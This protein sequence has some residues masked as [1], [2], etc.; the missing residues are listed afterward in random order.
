[1]YM[2]RRKANARNRS[3][4]AKLNMAGLPG[5]VGRGTLSKCIR[6][7]GNVTLK[8]RIKP[9]IPVDFYTMPT[10]N[11]VKTQ[12][13]LSIEQLN[14]INYFENYPIIKQKNYYSEN[15]IPYS[16]VY[17]R[18]ID[19]D[20]G[21]V[22]LTVPAIY[23][24]QETIT[25][26]P[27]PNDDFFPRMNQ[28]YPMGNA[29]AYHLGFF[30]ALTIE[31]DNILLDLNGKTLK[32][33][34]LHNIQQRFYANI[35]LASAPF[36]PTQGPAD[37]GSTIAIPKN[38]MIKNGTLGLSS[39]HGI[40]GNK[41][42]KVIIQG[43]TINN[44][45][46]AAIAL[47]GTNNSI[48]DNINIEGTSLDIKVLS[49]YSSGRFI[50]RFL[51]NVKTN[52]PGAF[53][54]VF[55]T[56]ISI[57]SIISELNIKLEELRLSVEN[58][59]TLPVSIFTNTSG[60]YDGNVYGI[61]L[62]KKG[63]VVNGFVTSLDDV[64]TGNRD[65]LLN[66]I[67]I[68]NIISTP[69]EIVG[70]SCPHPE[71]G[72]YGA[73]VQVGPAGDV[74]QI[75]IISDV[76]GK[77]IPNVLSNV[78]IIIGKYNDPK[79]GTTCIS[80]EVISWVEDQTVDISNIIHLAGRYFTDGGDSMAHSMKGNIGMFI[81]SGER[82][83]LNNV[84]INTVK[85]NGSLV[86]TDKFLETVN[87]KGAVSFGMVIAGSNMVDL[88]DVTVNNVFSHNG[89]SNGI[90]LKASTNITQNNIS[91]NNVT[92]NDSNSSTKLILEN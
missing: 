33:S 71:T 26:H 46:V 32:Q 56:I 90:M 19:F 66:N 89:D 4:G 42:E 83:R 39:H 91:I 24:L 21:T 43:L 5:L 54:E 63:V 41:M 11:S 38:I 77:Y 37:F 86:G 49:T 35:E 57:D 30:A 81:S 23:I 40:H 48:L 68:N 22:R 69:I 16:I 50:R 87:K 6:T 79:Q 64:T 51:N 14:S 88:K 28:N 80:P 62:N 74:L 55:G 70:V 85:N 10:F 59:T 25:F 17:L 15:I 13:G 9:Q 7:R 75:S 18:Q 8:P 92:S 72:A 84:S 47:N 67:N 36:I 58:S 82:I 20:N 65:V 27:N 45:E 44:F 31:S 12:S 2:Q 52:H 73:N 78:K 76:N 34:N 60:E 29:G 1:M 53:L 3:R 61:V